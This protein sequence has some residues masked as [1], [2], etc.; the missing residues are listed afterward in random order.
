MANLLSS[1]ILTSEQVNLAK[2][3]FSLP[4][5]LSVFSKRKLIV[6]NLIIN[7]FSKI[8]YI[9]CNNTLRNPS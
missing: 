2:I 4:A 6:K 3:E 9:V 7:F 1:M 5:C 8:F